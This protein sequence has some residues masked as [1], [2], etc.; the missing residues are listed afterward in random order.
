MAVAGCN[1]Q[2]KSETGGS[3][4]GEEKP[5]CHNDGDDGQKACFATEEERTA[6]ISRRQHE[7][8]TAHQSEVARSAAAQQ[9]A[10]DGDDD[11][12]VKR[13]KQAEANATTTPAPKDEGAQ[14]LAAIVPE[15]ELGMNQKPCATPPAAA[16]DQQRTECK[17]L[18]AAAVRGALER[19]VKTALDECEKQ[20]LAQPA[21]APFP[22]CQME[23]PPGA[24]PKGDGAAVPPEKL[25]CVAAC[26][27][28]VEQDRNAARERE[29][30]AA[31]AQKLVTAYKKCMMA[32]DST[33]EARKY[34]AYDR[35]LYDQLMSKTDGRCRAANKC[36]WLEK[37][38][39]EWQC[40]YGN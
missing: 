37:Y 8:L 14:W 34:E 4:F 20:A 25:S 31:Q 13:R 35:E 21:N 27:E 23:L 18:C 36:D 7:R 12:P 17:T 3:L 24:D 26:K 9:R 16:T 38:S 11:V 2:L 40:A 5:Y 29:R 33:L 39:E 19:V 15:C 1:M 22:A 30:A 6:D 28:I 10:A 32:V